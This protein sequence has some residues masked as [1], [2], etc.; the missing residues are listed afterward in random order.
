MS[1]PFVNIYHFFKARKAAFYILLAVA[2]L[3]ILLLASQIR[4]EEDIT[5]A[6]SGKA[7][8]DNLGWVVRNLPI[9]DKLIVDI[10]LI[11][12]L[13]P[14]DPDELG[15]FGQRLVD[16]LNT[17]FDTAYIRNIT[18]KASD[19]AMFKMMDLVMG[20]LP[21]FFD[22]SDY[23]TLDSLLLPESLEKALE[24][25]YKILTSPASI[26][27]KKRI[28]E[29]PLGISNIAFAKLNSLRAGDNFE[30]YNGSVYTSNLHHLLIFIVPTNPSSETSKNDKLIKGLDEIA[31]NLNNEKESRVHM[32]YFGGVAVAVCNARQLKKD[33]TLTLVIAIVLIFLL[34]GWYFKSI[35]VPLLG[36]LPALF[37]GALSLAILFLVKGKISAISLGIGSVILGLIVDYSLYLVNHFR[38]KQ[39]IELALKEMSLTIVLCSITSAGAFFCLTFLNSVVLQD[40]GWFAIFSVIGAALFTLTVLPHFIAGKQMPAAKT[41][42]INFVDKLASISYEKN[43]WLIAAL[44][45]IGALSIWFSQKVEFEKNMSTLS[46]VT[47]KLAKAESEL[48]KISNYKLK[49]LYLVATGKT[50]EKALRNQEQMSDRVKDLVK[51][52]K[53]QGISN[54]GSLL[55]S[56]SLQKVKIARWNGYWTPDRK[57]QLR[58]DLLIQIN[59]FGYRTSAF[60]PF[61]NLLNKDY[62]TL[63]ENEVNLSDNQLIANWI[64]ITPDLVLAPTILKVTETDK[65]QV[66]NEFSASERYVLFD[67]Q[68]LTTRFVEN[69][70]N[71]FDLLVALSMIFVTLLLIFSFGRIGLGLITALPMFFSWLITM[72]F[73]GITGIRFNIFN[74]IISSFIFGLGV[75]YS[76]L[77]MRG[78]QQ[79]L[80]TGKDDMHTYKVSVLL[81]SLTTLFGVGAL[82]FARHPALNSIAMVS[83]VGIASVVILSFVFQPLIFNEVILSRCR[84]NRFPVTLRILIKTL[85]TWGNIVAIALILMILGGMINLLLPI[86][87][88]KKEMLFHKLFYWL[89]KGYIAFTFAWDRKLINEP[90]E[91]FTK[92][93]IIISNHQSLIETPAFLRLYPKIIILTTSW[94]YRSPIFGPIAR[95]ANFYNVDNG[96]ESIIGL[97][98]EKVNEGFSILIFPEAHRSYEQQ[99]QRFHRGAF[100]LAEK[101]QID[102]LPILV[103]GTGDFLGKGA[104]WGRPNSFRMKILSRVGCDDLSFGKTYQ[105]RTRQFRQFYIA[106]YSKFKAEEGTAHYYRRK[107]ALNYILKGPILEWYMRVKL[108][109]ENNY[110]IYN[111]LM[112][113]KGE[114]L[115]LGCGYGFISYMLMFTGDERR[116]TGVDFDSEKIK[117]ANNCF[118]KNS[119][120]NFAFSDVSD[121][122]ITPKE[123]F[124]LCDVLHYL[125]PARQESLLRN[126]FSNLNPGGTILIREANSELENRHKKSQLTEFLST[127]IGF[128]K[129]QTSEKQLYFT[130]AEKIRKMAEESGM[131]MEVIDNKKVTSNNLYVLRHTLKTPIISEMTGDE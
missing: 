14:A 17:H 50:T 57:N 114:I 35:R 98:K 103:F 27:L 69:V 28:Q 37:G 40:L 59:K 32:Q 43:K 107:L 11:D 113:V 23:K 55:I 77:M 106:Q 20:H 90:G 49:N 9:S 81:S 91:D 128:N 5:Q 70:K 39:D 18:F 36:L 93:A 7:D 8:T 51:N 4:F 100:F 127:R 66:Y 46:F 129:T 111:Q 53:I 97:L 80:K 104:F 64:S 47:P 52:G 34:V 125:S 26:V 76:I 67:K 82:F 25:D 112:P 78:L 88:K 119:R 99:I 29:D 126:C 131:S 115:D 24:K 44:L 60:D 72:G 63:T 33:I 117:V 68:S 30:L 120:I 2:S 105:E 58:A 19:S 61:F 89:T 22:E 85:V 10:S 3:T 116:I 71:D 79:T 54:A 16:S 96:I 124:L 102:I 45:L 65:V 108:K 75:D 101:L 15:A 6:V 94:V 74:I 62:N 41:N 130:S 95:L 123:G 1:D 109:L 38:K 42:P 87:R 121:Y 21:N 118:S 122:K 48:D 83:V 86:K 13:A 84:K 56:D 31:Q 110:E 73:M 92:P 12:S